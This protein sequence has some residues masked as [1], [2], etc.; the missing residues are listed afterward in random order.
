MDVG[1]AIA[2]TGCLLLAFGHTAIG[3]RWVLP[4]LRGANLPETP[5]GPRALTVSMLRFS[6][7]V[8]SLMLTLFG[9]LFVALAVADPGDTREVLLAWLAAFWTIA[10]GTALWFGRR[11]PRAMLRFPVPLVLALVAAMCWVTAA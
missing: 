2:G 6:W 10:A 9:V 3:N 7:V 11:R 1:M 8:V 4:N 5:F